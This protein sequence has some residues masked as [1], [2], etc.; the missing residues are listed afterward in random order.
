M[1]YFI[2]F[3]HLSFTSINNTFNQGRN[4]D[5][6]KITNYFE[7]TQNMHYTRQYDHKNAKINYQISD[8]T[9]YF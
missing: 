5:N 3:S 9:T 2:F 7:Y 6:K 8:Y 4:F 1:N